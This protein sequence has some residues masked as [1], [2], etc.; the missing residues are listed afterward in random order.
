MLTVSVVLLLITKYVLKYG[1][2]I[3]YVVNAHA[4]CCFS[5]AFCT[6]SYA[7]ACVYV[8]THIQSVAGKVAF[9]WLLISYRILKQNLTCEFE[10]QVGPISPGWLNIWK[11]IMQ[12]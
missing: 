5:C 3:F 8:Y 1:L 10:F 7:C 9:L 6:I 4:H 12:V 11:I 2:L